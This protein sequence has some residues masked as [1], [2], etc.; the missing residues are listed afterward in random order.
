MFVVSRKVNTLSKVEGGEKREKLRGEVVRRI[1]EMNVKV[2]SDD[3]F[4]G[5]VA[6]RQRGRNGSP[7]EKTEFGLESGDDEEGR[8]MLK[9]DILERGSC[10]VMEDDSRQL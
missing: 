10:R 6:A 8:Q 2:T 9:T 1:I 3:E 7:Q 4:T 5:V